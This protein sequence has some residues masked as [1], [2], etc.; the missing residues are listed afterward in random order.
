MPATRTPPPCFIAPE[1]RPGSDKF[2]RHTVC[3]TKII[4]VTISIP[5]FFCPLPAS[6]PR[7]GKPA[8]TG[9]YGDHACCGAARR[10][11][12]RATDTGA[13]ISPNPRFG[14]GFA[15]PPGT[16][17]GPLAR[18]TVFSVS[19]RLVAYDRITFD[20]TG[21]KRGK[22]ARGRHGSPRSPIR[23]DRGGAECGER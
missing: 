3:Y 19:H 6:L 17:F 12:S 10:R 4:F 8:A 23:A 13:G 21:V 11:P 9:T 14:S 20:R 5:K 7:F 2:A 16:L 22:R 1:I 15:H 18:P